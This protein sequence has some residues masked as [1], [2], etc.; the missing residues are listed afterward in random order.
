MVMLL[1]ITG[2]LLAIASFSLFGYGMGKFV[3]DT[4]Y[5]GYL[6]GAIFMILYSIYL[7]LV[8]EEK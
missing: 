1:K 5:I 8:S 3:D 2:G 6:L 4:N 7:Q